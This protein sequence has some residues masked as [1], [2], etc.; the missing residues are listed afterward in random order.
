MAATRG[1][2]TSATRRRRWTAFG[3]PAGLGYQQRRRRRHEHIFA[4][5]A[6][7][8]PKPTADLTFDCSDRLHSQLEFAYRGELTFLKDGRIHEVLPN[9]RGRWTRR[10]FIVPSGLHSYAWRVVATADGRP[11]ARLDTVRC[12]NVP[13]TANPTDTCQAEAG[14]RLPR[15]R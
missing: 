7:A 14:V 12:L 15:L 8:D 1:A 3:E 9:V 5:T 2:S 10:S 11:T 13:P 4:P 6:N